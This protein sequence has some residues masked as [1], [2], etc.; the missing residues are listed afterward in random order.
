MAGTGDLRLAPEELRLTVDPARFRFQKTDEVAP[1]EEFVGQE[2]AIR[3]LEFGLSVERPGYNIFVSGLTGTGRTSAIREYVRR[4]I[5]RQQE[6]GATRI[7]D[8]WCYLY[9]FRDPDRPQAI[10]LPAGEG[11]RLRDSLRELLENAQ[12]FIKRAFSSEEYEQQRRELIEVSQRE[13]QRLMEQA[14]Q[15]AQA[16]G[17]ALRFSPMGVTI[18]PL[19]G[20]RPATPEEVASLDPIMRRALEER[21]RQV[22]EAV[23]EVGERL[24][25]LE[26]ELVQKLRELDRQVGQA[27][28]DALFRQAIASFQQYPQVVSYLEELRSHTLANLDLFRADQPP[29]PPVPRPSPEGQVDPF[30]AFRCNLFVDNGRAEGPP[31]VI[32]TNPTWSNLFGRIERKAYMGTYFSDHTL[33]RPG[34]VHR[35]NGGYLILDLNDLVTKPGSWEGLKRVLRTGQVRLE[36]PM[37]GLGLLVPQG[38]RPEPIPVQLKVI[39]TGDPLSYFL[40]STYDP[41]FWE[42]FKVKADF[43]YQIPLTDE[44]VGLYAR[45]VSSC[46]RDESLRPFQ[47]DA[48]A[49]I[50]EHASRMVEDQEKLTARFGQLR[51][52]LVEAD[53]WAAQEGSEVITAQHVYRAIREKYYRLNLV[54]ERVREL[55]SRGVIMV[56]VAGQVV[57]QVNGLA[58]LD[59][60]DFSFGRPSRITARVFLGQRGIVSIDRESQLSG[61]IHDKGVFTIS[62]YLGWKYAQERPLSL[63]ASVSFEQ[64]YEPV[65]GDSASLA[66]LCAILSAVAQV[67]IRQ[68]LAVTGSVNQKGEVQPVGGVN[69]KIEGFFEVCRAKGLTGTQGVIVPARNRRHL[70]LREEVVEAVRQGQFHVYAVETV[71][72]ALELLTGLPAGERQP[73]GSYPEGSLNALVDARLREMGE[74]LRRAGRPREREEAEEK[75]ETP[76]PEGKEQAS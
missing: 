32:E 71:D 3:A 11:R 44:T 37:E 10:R 36:D 29:V 14:Q 66:E 76:Q 12:A 33:L 6:A 27:A 69:Q 24:R 41:H 1:L 8:D 52:I 51:D 21:Q 23:N 40:L 63:S 2:R 55:I 22:S 34:A 25:A 45:F 60:G 64:A 62:G 39:I 30:L 57:G 13:A 72:Q 19:I 9:N 61:R 65:E 48:V 46:C 16:A 18:V 54:E 31:I 15:Q 53:Y 26:Q 7:P 35:A 73:D 49:K 5:A 28:V 56:D 70:N 17:F 74:A 75:E 38:L 68:D 47:A 59:M 42:L 43:D 67:P 58:V 20:G 4:A 50:I